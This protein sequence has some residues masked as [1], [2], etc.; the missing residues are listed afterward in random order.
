MLYTPLCYNDVYPI[1]AN[2]FQQFQ[3]IVYKNRQC[4]VQRLDDGSF[5]MHQLLSTNPY[6]YLEHA[7]HPGTIINNN[8]IM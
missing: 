2:D 7:F 6:D 1:N 4:Y 5:Q 3:M 8:N